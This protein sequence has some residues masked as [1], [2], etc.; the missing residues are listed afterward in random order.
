MQEYG[1]ISVEE[2]YTVVR[3][4]P[5]QIPSAAE[6]AAIEG[7]GATSEVASTAVMSGNFIISIILAASLN[8]LWA[9]M[10]GLQLAVHL[11]I[12]NTVFPAN[13]NFFISF[14]I[15]VATFDILPGF[16]IPLIFDFPEREP[17]SLGLMTCGYGSRYS[18]GNL[19]T[20]FFL[21]LLMIFQAIA[22]F[23]LS[24]FKDRYAFAKKHYEKLRTTLFWNVFLRF[25]FEGYLELCFSVFVSLTDLTW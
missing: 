20:C 11:P 13:A 18:I 4:L 25:F 7:A 17:Y 6:A 2:E 5:R 12:F 3:P 24:F 14:L 15:S 9:L 21:I 8:Q 10:N 23:F 1:D 19:G 22:C 16:I